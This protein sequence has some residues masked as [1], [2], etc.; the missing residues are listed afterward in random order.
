MLAQRDGTAVVGDALGVRVDKIW[1]NG[2]FVLDAFFESS[3]PHTL[4]V[5]KRR[6]RVAVFAGVAGCSPEKR[7]SARDA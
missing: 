7:F 1:K 5:M 3:W 2:D 6:T 4:A